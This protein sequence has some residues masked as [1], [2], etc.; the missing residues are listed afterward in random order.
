MSFYLRTLMFVSSFQGLANLTGELT[1]LTNGFFS[2]CLNT[3]A[4]SG[5]LFMMISELLSLS[6]FDSMGDATGLGDFF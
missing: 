2:G 4:V 6:V 3:G 5:I 1:Y